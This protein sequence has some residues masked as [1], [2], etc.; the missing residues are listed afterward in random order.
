MLGAKVWLSMDSKIWLQNLLDELEITSA[1]LSK[2]TGIDS[3]VISNIINGKRKAGIDTCL[4]IA[5]AL[6]RPP[7]E[8][9]RRASLLPPSPKPDSA[10]DEFIY[11]WEQ[12]PDS[13]KIDL[14]DNAR[15]KLKRH[16]RNQRDLG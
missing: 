14:L 11:I 7:E 8:I 1:D 12:L 10:R 13:E 6:K 4:R 5:K 3:A 2:L 16:E 15:G 9:Y